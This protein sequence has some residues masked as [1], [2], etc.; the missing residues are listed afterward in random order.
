VKITGFFLCVVGAWIGSQPLSA[1]SATSEEVAKLF[2]A[3]RAALP[4][5]S[6]VAEVA[7]T[8]GLKATTGGERT[9]EYTLD[10]FSDG[11]G[12]YY[13][14]VSNEVREGDRQ[15]AVSVSQ[16]ETETDF[17]ASAEIAL[18]DLW[19]LPHAMPN[20]DTDIVDFGWTVNFPNGEVR[21]VISYTDSSL[22]Q[23]YGV[24]PVLSESQI[25]ACS[26]A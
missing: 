3:A 6:Q 16:Y 11:S 7:K 20:R 17:A 1:R 22:T 9:P 19:K 4:C 14:L 12:T 2:D 21:V 24:M 15:V 26:A 23:I 25:A 10:E 5:V 13:L 18:S 8:Y